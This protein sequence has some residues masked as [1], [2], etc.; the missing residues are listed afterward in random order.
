MRL[1][2]FGLLDSGA[3]RQCRVSRRAGTLGNLL[4]RE[5]RGRGLRH[6]PRVRRARLGDDGGPAVSGS[7]GAASRRWPWPWP[8]SGVVTLL[9]VRG[10]LPDRACGISRA[11]TRHAGVMASLATEA[12]QAFKYL[13][14]TG[15]LGVLGDAFA[16]SVRDTR[17][18][19]NRN[20][21]VNHL[22]HALREPLLVGWIGAV[23]YV[24]VVV[25]RQSLGVN[26]RRE[27]SSSIA[28]RSSWRCCRTTGTTSSSGSAPS[29]PTSGCGPS[30]RAT[31]NP[32]RGPSRCGSRSP[33]V[34]TA[35]GSPTR[36][37]PC[38]EV[39]TSRCPSSGRWRSWGPRASARAPSWISWRAAGSRRS[40][41]CG[42]MGFDLRHVRRGDYRRALGYVTQESVMFSGSVARNVTMSWEGDLGAG[43]AR[44]RPPRRRARELSRAHRGA[45]AGLG[46]GD[47][48]A[49]GSRL[50]GG[51]RAAHCAG[52]GA[53]RRARL[54]L[55][56]DEATSALDSFSERAVQQS[57]ERLHGRVTLLLVSHRLSTLRNADIVYVLEA[58]RVVERGGVY[59][60]LAA[61]RRLVPP[62]VRDAEPGVSRRRARRPRLTGTVAQSRWS[63]SI[64]SS[65]HQDIRWRVSLRASSM[66]GGG[67]STR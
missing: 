45:R 7:G 51:E 39:S 27:S 29:T 21:V 35:S 28:C 9:L 41:A 64:M 3:Y 30:W 58:G 61:P 15:R 44:A 55:I 14:A 11:R 40:G 56:C 31:R 48:R 6:E 53:L 19:E 49:G 16:G 5:I 37:S 1:D 54:L 62:V 13:R 12:V 4:V 42:S 47:R 66:L 22:R 60:A 65:P 23:F 8:L 59:R 36:G 38:C 63:C 2:V 52:P 67:W 25:L 43:P 46:H 33:S 17:D 24:F 18:L 34:W 20:A 10:L 50:S 26:H 57:L 32:T